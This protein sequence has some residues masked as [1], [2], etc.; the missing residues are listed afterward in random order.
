MCTMILPR[1]WK[2]YLPQGLFLL[3]IYWDLSCRMEAVSFRLGLECLGIRRYGLTGSPHRRQLKIS[4]SFTRL[5]RRIGS[6]S[7][8]RMQ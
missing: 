8:A 7:R 1:R 6:S 2:A 4:G 5:R 3:K